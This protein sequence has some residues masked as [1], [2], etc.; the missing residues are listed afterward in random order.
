MEKTWADRLIYAGAFLSFFGAY[1][2]FFSEPA[3][4]Q[5]QQFF[6]IGV[7]A[8]GLVLGVIGLIIKAMGGRGSPP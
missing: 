4:N 6:R 7:A 3:T 8:V 5:K 1:L 2:L